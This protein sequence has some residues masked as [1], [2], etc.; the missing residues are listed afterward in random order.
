M[1][2]DKNS[3]NHLKKKI[4]RNNIYCYKKQIKKSVSF[5]IINKLI[6]N[7]SLIKSHVL[8]MAEMWKDRKRRRGM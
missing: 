4:R 7:I 5:E 8:I 3:I 6:V 2:H 1:K